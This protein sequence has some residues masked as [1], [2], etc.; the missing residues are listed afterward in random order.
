MVAYT[1]QCLDEDCVNEEGDVTTFTY[2]AKITDSTTPP[3][4][5]CEGETKK[6]ITGV[7]MVKLYGVGLYKRTL[8]DK[9]DWA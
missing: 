9:G 6:I 3:C 2:E 5:R 1:A 4:P 7:G 8:R